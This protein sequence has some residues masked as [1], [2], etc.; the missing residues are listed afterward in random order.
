MRAT[1]SQVALTITT[2]EMQWVAPPVLRE[3]LAPFLRR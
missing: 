1:T 3:K 2:S